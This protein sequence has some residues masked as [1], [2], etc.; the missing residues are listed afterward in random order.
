[1]FN[2][3]KNYHLFYFYLGL[4]EIE[5]IIFYIFIGS[6]IKFGLSVLTL[7]IESFFINLFSTISFLPPLVSI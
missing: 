7:V 4:R 3:F 2:I 1:M 6:F 5:Y